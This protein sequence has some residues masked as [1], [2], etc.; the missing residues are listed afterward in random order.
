MNN[1]Q[2]PAEDAI[3][4]FDDGVDEKGADAV[5]TFEVF[6]DLKQGDTT[7]RILVD[8][9]CGGCAKPCKPAEICAT[10]GCAISG[11]ASTFASRF[12]HLLEEDG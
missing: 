1:S 8:Y 5:G 9:R 2:K 6:V 11:R 12:S 10:A 3:E 4:D 7:L